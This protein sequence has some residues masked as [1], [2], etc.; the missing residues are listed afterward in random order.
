M[1]TCASHSLSPLTETQSSTVTIALWRRVLLA[2]AALLAMGVGAALV[3]DLPDFAFTVFLF[4]TQD[5]P[6]AAAIILLLAL[7]GLTA[8]API[9]GLCGRLS[10]AR[11]AA[12]IIALATLIFA[13]AGTFLVF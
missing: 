2:S 12:T 10:R 13:F 4:Q 6:T 8:W 7:L 11:G 5:L 9:T 3:S 1:Q